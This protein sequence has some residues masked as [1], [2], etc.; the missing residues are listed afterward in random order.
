ML[1][2][3]REWQEK[4]TKQEIYE[5]LVL[6]VSREAEKGKPIKPKGELTLKQLSYGYAGKKKYWIAIQHFEYVK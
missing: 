3:S 6:L 1:S 4:P 5:W 2:I